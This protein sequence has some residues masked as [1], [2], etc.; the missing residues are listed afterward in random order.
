MAPFASVLIN[1]LFWDHRFPRL[2]TRK[3]LTEL[4]QQVRN[5]S[6]M[7]AYDGGG[8]RLLEE[9]WRQVNTHVDLYQYAH[10]KTHTTPIP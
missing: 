3:Q 10:Q 9:L 7:C 1:G 4:W 8:R 2:L 5:R 6:Y